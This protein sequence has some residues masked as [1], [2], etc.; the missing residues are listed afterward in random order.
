MTTRHVREVA[1]R[2]DFEDLCW[3]NGLRNRR[4]AGNALAT[5]HDFEDLCWGNGLRN[6]R[7]AGNALCLARANVER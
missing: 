3:G 6:R 7:K 2:H 1:T 5:R 4:K